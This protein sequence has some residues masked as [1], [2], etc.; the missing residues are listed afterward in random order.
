MSIRYVWGNY[1]EL[2]EVIELAKQGKVK[3]TVPLLCM[4]CKVLFAF[5]INAINEAI[6]LFRS[7]Q[8]DGRAVI[9]P[10]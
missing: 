4:T 2:R 3:H 6:S 5:S 7:G 10:K 8:V 1:N 9:I